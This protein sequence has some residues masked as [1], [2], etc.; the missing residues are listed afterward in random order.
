MKILDFLRNRSSRDQFAGLVIRQLRRSGWSQ[1][2]GYDHD[3]F[4]LVLGDGF[5]TLF[6][7]NLHAEW[8]EA[9]GAAKHAV[10]ERAAAFAHEQKAEDIALADVMG[11]LLPVVRNLSHL[12]NQ[13]LDPPLKADKDHFD[14]ALK[15]FCGA[16]AISVAIDR[17]NSI[18]IL[19]ASRLRQWSRTLDDLLPIA[20]DNLRA[21]SPSKFERMKEGHFVSAYNDNY[22]ASRLLLPDLFANLPLRGN[23]VAV[24]V[25]RSCLVVCGS[26]EL[27]ALVAMAQFAEDEI[28]RDQRAISFLPLV[29]RDGSWRR[30]D[31]SDGNV[32]ALSR[33][34]VKQDLWDYTEQKTLLEGYFERTGRD[35]FVASLEALEYEGRCHTWAVWTT[36]AVSLLPRADALAIR[37]SEGDTIVR[38]WADIEAH[39]GPLQVEPGM[40]PTRYLVERRPSD[41]CL[42]SLRACPAPEWLPD[43]NR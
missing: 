9:G 25:S 8:R 38:T 16:L 23:P 4:S 1:Q 19:A 32:P 37:L 43:P 30:F 13:W 5:G 29:L 11:A 42:Q 14:Y 28:D 20:L 10:V 2:V 34:C 39:C 3:R 18:K 12:R 33:L 7:H 24:A 31:F 36:D 40:T 21:I 35:I 6:L 26:H 15:E 41:E 22:D 17:P 27:D